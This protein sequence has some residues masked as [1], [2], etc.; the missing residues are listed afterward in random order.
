MNC[1]M[2]SLGEAKVSIMKDPEEIRPGGFPQALSEDDRDTIWKVHGFV[3]MVAQEV[4]KVKS[5][6]A[7]FQ[8]AWNEQCKITK[9]AEQRGIV[10][11]SEQEKDAQ[12]ILMAW[13]IFAANALADSLFD[14]DL[15]LTELKKVSEIQVVRRHLQDTTAATKAKDYLVK[16]FPQLKQ[17]RHATAHNAEIKVNQEKNSFSGRTSA[18][19]G[20]RIEDGTNIL[21]T[22]HISRDEFTTMR[23]G[24]ILKLRINEDTYAKVLETYNQCLMGFSPKSQ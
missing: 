9:L 7:L 5:A 17:I 20:I 21:V 1:S 15:L 8:F 19:P 24:E 22:D 2:S 18:I 11:L 14:I 10:G 16:H 3:R 6:V 4:R 23:K 13:P 12:R